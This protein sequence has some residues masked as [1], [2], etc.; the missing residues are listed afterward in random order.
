MTK[1]IKHSILISLL[2][3][4]SCGQNERIVEAKEK[5]LILQVINDETSYFMAHDLEKWKE[6]FWEEDYAFAIYTDISPPK[7]GGLNTF[8]GSNDLFDAA[9]SYFNNKN[10]YNAKPP[11][12]RDVNIQIRGNVA[13]VTFYETADWGPY[14]I[15]Q[16]G[17]R[18]LEKRNEEW[19]ISLIAAVSDLSNSEPPFQFPSN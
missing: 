12:K 4:Y 16:S 14:M 10:K 19:K 5:Q 7:S 2:I 17:V 8:R 15:P 18:I 9:E 13:W 11:V 6:L 3:F 1:I